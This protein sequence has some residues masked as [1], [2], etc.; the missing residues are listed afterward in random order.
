MEF[1]APP[2]L[3]TA[4]VQLAAETLLVAA[5]EIKLL[6]ELH[7]VYGV[8]A[9]RPAARPSDGLRRGLDG[10]ARH[11]PA[12]AVAAVVLPGL[13]G[14]AGPAQPADPPGRAAT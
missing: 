8:P 2:T 5:I 9:D 10:A 4:P 14:E 3:L 12:V 11:R 6:A 13:L 1:A 7:E